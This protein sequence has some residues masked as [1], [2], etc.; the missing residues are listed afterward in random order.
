MSQRQASDMAESP[1]ATHETGGYLAA[2]RPFLE[3]CGAQWSMGTFGAIAEFLRDPG[4]AAAVSFSDGAASVATR[5]G[6]L[7]LDEHMRARLVAFEAI[8]RTAGS[9]RHGVAIC[10]PE[11][12]C[13]MHG[14]TAVTELGPDREALR[15]EDSAGILFDLGLALLQTDACI[16]TP[17]AG[18]IAAL[19]ASEGRSLFDPGNA[20]M[21]DILRVGPHRVFLSR[22][23]RL[24]VYQPIPPPT[25]KS[26]L[27]PHTH[28]LPK[29]L[30]AGRT[31]AATTPIPQGWVPCAQLYP[32]HALFDDRGLPR[33]FVRAHFD[34]FAKLYARHGDGELV[35]LEQRV[36]QAVRAGA[37][38]DALALPDTKHARACVR[39]A[40]RKL[41]ASGEVSPALDLWLAQ[42]DRS[43][44][45]DDD[46][47]HGC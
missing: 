2:V 1:C 12:Q 16:R 8:S 7:R 21:M 42:H 22:L 27:G 44:A 30:R 19:R 46:A 10:L 36:R 37:P 3:D 23:G 41:K 33:A 20:V 35:Q 43:S 5:R 9:W 28:I 32:P 29:L 13:A 34:D 25:G 39:I 18:L 15:T 24:E 11:G 14:R 45:D 6:G 31:H 4:E 40:L 26:P 47:P 38:P 17:D